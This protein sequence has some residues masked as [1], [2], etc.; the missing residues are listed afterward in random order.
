[1]GL[2]LLLGDQRVGARVDESFEESGGAGAAKSKGN[3]P[4]AGL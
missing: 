2:R 4:R 3:S 1:M